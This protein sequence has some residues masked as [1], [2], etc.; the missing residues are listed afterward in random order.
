M[1]CPYC[2]T[3]MQGGR[4]NVQSS[5]GSF[6]SVEWVPEM[7]FKRAGIS[8]KQIFTFKNRKS[9]FLHDV[10]NEGYYCPNCKKLI[11]VFETKP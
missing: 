5:M 3:I 9:A 10:A 7:D 2:D 11:C 6:P 1:I 8:L 4:I